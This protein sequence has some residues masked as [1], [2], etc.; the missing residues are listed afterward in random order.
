MQ[1]KPD[2]IQEEPSSDNS[3]AS[4][5]LISPEPQLGGP[6]SD[7]GPGVKEN[8]LTGAV[9]AGRYSS[10]NMI[11]VNSVHVLLYQCVVVYLKVF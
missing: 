6:I 4:N 5:P 7:P 10:V 11:S 3:E 8:A 9:Q 2:D 1:G